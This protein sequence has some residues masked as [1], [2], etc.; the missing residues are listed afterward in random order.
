MKLK[1]EKKRQER[2]KVSGKIKRD[3]YCKPFKKVMHNP[4]TK[5]PASASH[6]NLENKTK[7][8]QKQ[9]HRFIS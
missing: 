6:S 7:T 4:T 5:E 3:D 9:P 1:T 2:R 8:A